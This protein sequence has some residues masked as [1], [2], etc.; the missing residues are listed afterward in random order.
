MMIDTKRDVNSTHENWVMSKRYRIGILGATGVVG[1][2]FIEL[3]DGHPWFETAELIASDRS[4]GKLYPEAVTWMGTAPIP[5]AVSETTVKRVADP[6]QCDFVFSGLDSSV[7]TELESQFAS[8]GLPVISNAKNFRS[9]PT[10]PLLIPEV[11]PDHLCL[12]QKQSWPN[13]GFIVTNPNCSIVGVVCST[14]P[15]DDAFGVDALQ[16]TTMQALSGAGYPGVSSLDIQGNVLPF[17][18][19]EE[20]KLEMEPLKL[21]GFVVDSEVQRSEISISAQCNRV[22][23]VDGYLISIS[24]QFRE[25][26]SLE[27]VEGVFRNFNSPS[28][29]IDLPSSPDQFLHLF[30]DPECPQPARHSLL[31]GGMTVSVGRLKACGVLDYRFVSLVHNTIRGAAGGAILNAELLVSKGYIGNR[32]F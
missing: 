26:A 4:V 15:L 23:V 25:K 2:K 11:N 12:I 8:Q 14:K 3:L 17:I 6:L 21:L 19:G 16:I 18:R 5:K 29:V 9:D 13:G 32:D 20:E 10:V 30:D 24:V 31:G 22:P 27:D 28:D 7:A 1:Q